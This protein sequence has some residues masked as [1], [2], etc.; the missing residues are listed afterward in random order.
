MARFSVRHFSKAALYAVIFG[1]FLSV[2]GYA[3]LPHTAIAAGAGSDSKTEPP[4]VKA[5]D[6]IVADQ[7]GNQVSL[8]SMR[9]KPIVLNF[10]A[11]WCP[12]CKAEMPEFNAVY[13]EV[14]REVVFM[15]IDVVDGRRETL[16]KA[17]SYLAGQKFSFP[18]YFDTYGS[19]VSAYGITALPTTIFIDKDGY[20]VTG[21]ESMINA[22]VLRM[23]IALAS[24]DPAV[25][26][27]VPDDKR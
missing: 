4:R 16:Q 6:F 12:P 1:L 17:K 3:G 22:R 11:S 20:V 9:G 15:M 23:G 24:T 13:K 26:E 19:A 8:S 5:P 10:W 27:A 25:A 2:A 7:N 14:G 21:S 18:V